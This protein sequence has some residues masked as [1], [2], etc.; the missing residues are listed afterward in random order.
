MPTNLP[1][2]KELGPCVFGSGINKNGYAQ[3]YN[4]GKQVAHHRLIWEQ[5]NGPI[6]EGMHIDHICHN[7]AVAHEMCAGQR[8]CIHRCCIN[9]THLRMLTPSEN[10]LEGLRGLRNRVKCAKGH[11]LAE[12]GIVVRKRSDGKMGDRCKECYLS[13]ARKATAAYK[14]RKKGI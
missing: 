3:I 6:P 1:S 8:N 4:K 9:P 12:V 13:V 11:V 14:A 2:L 10:Q 7:V 5:L